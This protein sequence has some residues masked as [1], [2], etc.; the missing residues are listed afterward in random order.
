MKREKDNDDADEGDP[1][2]LPGVP[3]V[4][5]PVVVPA[6]P[7]VVPAAVAERNAN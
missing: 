3:A 6:P 2:V 1:V 4:A 7:A 5:P